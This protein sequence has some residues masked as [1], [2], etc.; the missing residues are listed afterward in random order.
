MTESEKNCA[1]HIHRPQ[2]AH[3]TTIA[4]LLRTSDQMHTVPFSS[5]PI[6]DQACIWNNVTGTRGRNT[7]CCDHVCI[8]NGSATEHG[9]SRMRDMSSMHLERVC[10]GAWQEQ[11]AG[12]IKHASGT[13]LLRSMA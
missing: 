11:N 12:H 6:L 2:N 3:R 10:Y 8:W 5:A 1:K 4:C 13:G 9:W 7:L